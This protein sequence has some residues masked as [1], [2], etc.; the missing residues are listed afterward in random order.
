MS[1]TVGCDRRASVDFDVLGC[2]GHH[3]IRPSS[4]AAEVGVSWSPMAAPALLKSGRPV[5][6]IRIGGQAYPVVLPTLRDPRLHLGAVIV[7]LQ[8]LGQVAFDFQLSIAQILVS[9]LTCAVLEVGIV[10]WRQRMF[11]WPASALL[12]G[13]GVAFILR[14]PGT[15]H[16]DWWS[17]HGAW[18]FASA[19]AVSLLSKYLIRIGGRQVFNPSNFG[20]VLCFLILG[21]DRA[22][23]LDFWWAPMSTE[24]AVALAL[25]VAGGVLILWR[26]RILEIAVIF[27]LT[28]AACIAVV[29]V[30]GHAMTARWHLGPIEGWDFWRTLLTSPEVLVFLFFMI[31]DPKT[32]PS[33][34]IQR[35]AFACAVAVLA[36]LLDCASANGVRKQGGPPRRVGVGVCRGCGRAMGPR[37]GRV[38]ARAPR[39]PSS[40]RRMDPGY[41]SQRRRTVAVVCLATVAAGLLVG[42]GIPARPAPAA[43]GPPASRQTSSRA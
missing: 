33:G 15:E 27:W 17:F 31:T 13:N 26:L 32:I 21:S 10:F 42:A 28:F 40:T 5:R 34:R 20:L 11:L 12:T 29:A 24:M 36:A 35:R 9:I 38:G 2:S 39:A 1:A 37:V 30:S 23:P 8:V 3:L 19:A 41:V 25:I 7:S 14:V 22:D 16:G 4:V 18:I 43:A 6:H